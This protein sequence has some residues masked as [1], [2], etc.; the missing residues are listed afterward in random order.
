[1]E[2]RRQVFYIDSM[3]RAISRSKTL[4]ERME[5]RIARRRGDVFLRQDF[6]DLGGYVQ[7]G[8]G[9]RRLVGT[10]KLVRIGQGLYSRASTSPFDGRI[11]PVKSL[12]RL[13]GEAFARL[14][15]ETRPTR[16]QRAYNEGRSTQVPVG[17]VI[18][19]TR[20]VRRKISANG[21]TMGY[22][23]A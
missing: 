4:A 5:E 10:G 14:G 11:I 22:E 6:A 2:I 1:V 12:Y 23:R 21:A 16:A 3:K 13:A 7:V 17:R 20:R 15:I 9:L 19:V 8:R 18:G